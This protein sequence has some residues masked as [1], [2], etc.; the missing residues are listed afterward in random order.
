M[1]NTLRFLVGAF[2]LAIFALSLS[3]VTAPDLAAADDLPCWTAPGSM[4]FACSELDTSTI[5]DLR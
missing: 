1:T 3:L 4:F 5:V 2:G